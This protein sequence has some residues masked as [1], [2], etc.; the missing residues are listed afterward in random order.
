MCIVR[1]RAASI[2]RCV[3]EE[4]ARSGTQMGLAVTSEARLSPA[5]IE[6]RPPKKLSHGRYSVY[7]HI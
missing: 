4:G 7:I 3:D 6:W 1:T 5:S 2:I